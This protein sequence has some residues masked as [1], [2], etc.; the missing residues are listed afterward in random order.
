MA[1]LVEYFRRQSNKAN[2]SYSD[3]L[4][5]SDGNPLWSTVPLDL[6]ITMVLRDQS[7]VNQITLSTDDDSGQ[8]TAGDDGMMNVNVTPNTL[9]ALQEGMYDVW[10]K[11][12]T[13]DFT[14]ER[15]YGRLPICEGI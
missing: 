8:L 15:V 4:C 2:W 7:G 11:I 13:D 12:Y 9:N 5:G 1:T 14:I 6:V 3:Q 10:L